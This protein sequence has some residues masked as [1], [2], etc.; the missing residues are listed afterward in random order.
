MKLLDIAF[1]DMTRSFRSTFAV[2]FMFGVPLL[3]TG[4][5]YLMFGGTGAGKTFTVPVTTVAVANL[6]QGS[7]SFATLQSQL[8]ADTAG[9]TMG[10]ILVSHL[11]EKALADVIQVIRVDSVEAARAAVD[12]QQAGAAIIIPPDFSAQFVDPA[13]TTAIELYKD[14]TLTIGPGIVQS[15]LN[16]LLDS[17]S[18]AKI[19]VSVAVSA[20]GGADPALLG[21]V[22]SQFTGSGP[23]TQ[24]FDVRDAS[25]P[26]QQANA[27]ATIIG[28]IMGWLTLF[29]AFFTG[30][31]TA[32]SILKEDEEGTL[33]R[34]FTTPTKH[35]T[36]L[37]GK[38][39][40]VGLTV[41][42]QMVVLFLLGGYVF[43]IPWGA[44]VSIALVILGTILAAAGFG[45]FIN[46]MLKSTKQG[47]LIFGG[48]LTV[49]GM[50]G[51]LPIFV[52]G[53]SANDMLAKVGLF[54]PI[55]W[56]V[57]GLLQSMQSA[58]FRDVVLTAL[59]LAGWGVVFFIIG[60]LR[61]QKRYV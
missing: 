33:P 10:Q 18:G 50:L 19:A 8:P 53:S 49:M 20:D 58:A 34:L 2:V 5:F 31:S 9:Q 43:G 23:A 48:L 22:I 42:V 51:G 37:G 27:V 32:Q 13:G 16:Q 3:M 61:F 15:V 4:M 21:Q 54:E 38:F 28:P 46:S 25:V 7:P 29:Y 36:I 17:F 1:K 24:I 47:G 39:L 40:A 56:A 14:P 59:V 44:T 55:G 26:T 35:S 30:A 57:R 11:E 45:I 12:S 60:V 52:P 6:D 41:V